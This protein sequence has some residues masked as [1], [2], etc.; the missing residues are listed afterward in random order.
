MTFSQN[1]IY[2]IVGLVAVLLL[3]IYTLQSVPQKISIT[4]SYTTTSSSASLK[5]NSSYKL[6]DASGSTY[7]ILASVTPKVAGVE[8]TFQCIPD[9]SFQWSANMPYQMIVYS[10]DTTA[11]T[12]QLAVFNASVSGSS[13]QLT[14]SFTSNS[15]QPHY[16]QIIIRI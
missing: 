8:T 2:I 3:V 13:N 6:K 4:P 12:K 16:V 7:Y 11:T 5:D 9:I 1:E 10:T 14:G 15:V